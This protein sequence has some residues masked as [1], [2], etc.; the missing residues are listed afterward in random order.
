MFFSRRRS[1][2]GNSD[3]DRVG[4]EP[5]NPGGAET[6]S[7]VKATVDP[8]SL[9][10]TVESHLLA[11][12][13]RERSLLSLLELSNELNVR[14][15][16][17]EIADVALFNLLGHFGCSRGA[18]WLLP[19]DSSDAVLLRCQGMGATAARA[20]GAVWARW[21]A[22]RP[23]GILEPILVSDLKD[24]GTASGLELAEKNGVAVF[25]PVTSRRR[26]L[27]LLALGHRV[28]GGGFGTLDLEI[29]HGSVNFAGA[30]L[31][32]AHLFN[33]AVENN[34]HLRLAN[35]RLKE[36]DQLKSDFL[37]NMNH[38]LR[39]PLTI[40]AAYLDSLLEMPDDS[41]TRREHLTTI[42]SEAGKLQGMLLD[43]LDFSKLE[44]DDIEIRLERVDVRALLSKYHEDRRPGI[45]ADLREIRFSCAADVP[46]AMLDPARFLQI[47][48]ALV[49]NA[50]KFT[51]Q[52]SLIDL[53]LE[54]IVQN[55]CD[56]VRVDVSD[57]G[58][59][60]AA[61]RLPHVFES[62]RQ[63]D[64]S[65]TRVHGG[66]GVGLAMVRRLSQ[67][68][69]ALLDVQSEIGKGTVFSLILPT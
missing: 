1:R 43:L 15:D 52:G 65:E 39:T 51:P 32:N 7:T 66:M 40:I 31:E 68:M 36:L 48:G 2:D 14:M 12:K 64:G 11:R 17:Y 55:G 35:E 10:A 28:G 29:L 47:V 4:R 3:S 57:T 30:A 6:E 13:R 53:R 5:G 50:V 20:I 56:W 27:G 42:R 19:E 37:R 8:E 23:G 59:G 62:F 34:R 26:L 67:K 45:T 44:D 69:G 21:L 63:G 49:D 9:E 33:R 41:K 58:P 60:I 24:L 61:D 22:S 38:E 54:S 16:L 46:L 18:L 25:A